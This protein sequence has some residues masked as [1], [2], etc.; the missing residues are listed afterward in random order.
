[1]NKF[2]FFLLVLLFFCMFSYGLGL[3]SAWVLG[4]FG[5]H[6]PWYVCSVA[7][8]IVGFVFNGGRK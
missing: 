4:Y 5:V 3:A 8:M 2:M 1:M 6:V 7:I